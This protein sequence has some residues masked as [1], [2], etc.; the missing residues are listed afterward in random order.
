MDDRARALADAVAAVQ[1]ITDDPE[2][3][4]WYERFYEDPDDPE[5]ITIMVELDRVLDAI[6]GLAD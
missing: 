6:K 3:A 1:A 5:K 2:A 4:T